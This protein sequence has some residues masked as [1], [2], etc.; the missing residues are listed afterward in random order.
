MK[1][2]R[3]IPTE[4]KD[5]VYKTAINRSSCMM[6]SVGQL[7]RRRGGNSTQLKCACC[8]GQEERRD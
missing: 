5:K 6:Q 7:G 8:G 2:D 1:C 4:L 3:N